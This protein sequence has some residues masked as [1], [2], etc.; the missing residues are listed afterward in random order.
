MKKS[1]ILLLL[2]M[3]VFVIGM[4]GCAK[5]QTIKPDEK[6]E[7]AEATDEQAEFIP[8]ESVRDKSFSDSSD[9]EDVYFGFDNYNVSSRY[10]AI[11]NENA[12]WLNDQENAYIQIEGHCDERG[13]IEYN[14]ALGQRR[15]TSVRNYLIKLGI[16]PKKISTIS[17]GEEKPFDTGSNEDSW[18]ANRRAHF[19][20][21]FE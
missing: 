18:A 5:K 11:L 10:R 3:F 1:T 12:S 2:V 14:L 16:D 4:G 6:I 19:L 20:I 7:E 17:Y 13:T 21:R 8:E 15:A 9:L